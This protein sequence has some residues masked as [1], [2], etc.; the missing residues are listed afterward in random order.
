MRLDSQSKCTVVSEAEY[1]CAGVA[2]SVRQTHCIDSLGPDG[3]G[4]YEYY[5]EYDIYEIESDSVL[6]CARSYVEEP[7]AAHL[8]GLVENGTRRLLVENDFSRPQVLAALEYL[9]SRGKIDL[10]WLDEANN[11]D[12]YT[13]VP[14]RR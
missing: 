13:P 9:D 2:L 5:Y 1:R 10:T 6:V 12:G 14:R 4:F 8:L 7:Q 3:N 11:Y